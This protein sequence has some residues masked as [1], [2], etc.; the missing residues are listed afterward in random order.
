MNGT[1]LPGTPSL[2]GSATRLVVSAGFILMAAACGG[3][4]TSGG[5]VPSTPSDGSQQTSSGGGSSSAGS[6]TLSGALSGTDTQDS[7]APGAGGAC[8]LVNGYEQGTVKFQGTQ[9]EIVFYLKVGATTLPTSDSLSQVVFERASPAQAWA[10]AT[11]TGS[12]TVTIQQGGSG[13][14]DATL[15]PQTPNGAMLHVSGSWV[16]A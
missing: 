7:G 3:S 1:H 16:C 9:D 14:I 4:A 12:G 8:G 2:V 15:E 6:L 5:A 10:S 13:S 11:G